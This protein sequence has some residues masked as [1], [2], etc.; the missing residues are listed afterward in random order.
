VERGHVTV[1]SNSTD[2]SDLTM[3]TSP[4]VFAQMF[5]GTLD[6]D[7]ANSTGRLRLVGNDSK[8]P[9][10]FAMFPHP[11]VIACVRHQ[12]SHGGVDGGHRGERGQGPRFILADA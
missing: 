6:V 9:G 11:V 1:P 5:T 4:D 7:E 8:A 2:E 3:E 12:R 10:F